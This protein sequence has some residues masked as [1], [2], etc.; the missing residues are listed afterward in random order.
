MREET[1]GYRLSE[2]FNKGYMKVAAMDEGI[3]E[4][5]AA[6]FSLLNPEMFTEIGSEK[7]EET[8]K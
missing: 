5:R 3:S 6:D 7:K 4:F 8:K 1:T 2:L